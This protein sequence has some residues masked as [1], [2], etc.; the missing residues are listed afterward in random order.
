MVMR[1]LNK[2]QWPVR[3]AVNSDNT[4]DITPIEL[5]LGEQ[6]GTFRG[7]WNVVYHHNET[8]F[9]FKTQQDATWFA[10]KWA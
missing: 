1:I 6:L 3:V 8:H 2:E 4:K 9:Y 10:L 7:R 5:W